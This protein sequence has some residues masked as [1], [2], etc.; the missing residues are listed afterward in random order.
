MPTNAASSMVFSST[1]GSPAV[2][3]FIGDR[4]SSPPDFS[5]AFVGQILRR[6]EVGISDNVQIEQLVIAP[7][8][9]GASHF[10]RYYNIRAK[11]ASL[12]R[13]ESEALRLQIRSKHGLPPVSATFALADSRTII[14]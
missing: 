8:A 11:L 13:E 2:H 1:T 5:S 9:R 10:E 6:E 14:G 7:A 4:I 3:Y 12:T